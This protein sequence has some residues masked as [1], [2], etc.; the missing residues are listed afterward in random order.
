MGTSK[1]DSKLESDG[2]EG[3]AT[4]NFDTGRLK[5]FSEDY[6]HLASLADTDQKILMKQWLFFKYESQLKMQAKEEKR[7]KQERR[8]QEREARGQDA[9]PG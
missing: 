1:F 8:R 4:L 7:L 6:A 2:E 3:G 5:Q 9:S